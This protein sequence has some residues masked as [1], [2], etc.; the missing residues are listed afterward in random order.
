MPADPRAAQAFIRDPRFQS[1]T[2]PSAKMAMFRQYLA[3]E[4]AEGFGTLG[5]EEQTTV[6]SRLMTHFEP[7][8][9]TTAADVAEYV[10]V[11]GG[12]VRGA[13]EE[14]VRPLTGAL[15]GQP[16]STAGRVAAEVGRDVAELG[17]AVGV[18]KLAAPVIN[19][20]ARRFA[21]QGIEELVAGAFKTGGAAGVVDEALGA[22]SLETARRF[23]GEAARRAL[24]ERIARHGIEN[25]T[26]GALF[27]AT[28]ALEGEIANGELPPLSDILGS[29]FGAAALGMGFYGAGELLRKFRVRSLDDVV[30]ASQRFDPERFAKAQRDISE[31]AEAVTRASGGRLDRQGAVDL[32]MTALTEPIE[33]VGE[34][35]ALKDALRARPELL[36]SETGLHILRTQRKLSEPTVQL[37]DGPYLRVQYDDEAG[38]TV[39]EDLTDQAAQR[40]FARRLERGQVTVDTAVGDQ[41]SILRAGIR[42]G[43]PLET[44]VPAGGSRTFVAEGTPPARFEPLYGPANVPMVRPTEPTLADL[45]DIAAREVRTGQPVRPSPL[46]IVGARAARPEPAVRSPSDLAASPE[47]ISRLGRERAGGITYAARDVRGKGRERVL[48][49]TV[50]RIDTRPGPFEVIV[51]RGGTERDVIVEAG[52]KV[53]PAQLDRIRAEEVTRFR[54]EVAQRQTAATAGAPGL[55][56]PTDL[57]QGVL[58]PN[59]ARVYTAPVVAPPAGTVTKGTGGLDVTVVGEGD[60]LGRAP[61]R[62]P[63]GTVARLQWDPRLREFDVPETLLLLPGREGR[64]PSLTGEGR[65]LTPQFRAQVVPG[66]VITQTIQDVGKRDARPSI[67]VLAVDGD[68]V[69]LRSGETVLETDLATVARTVDSGAA[70]LAFDMTKLGEEMLDAMAAKF[71]VFTEPKPVPK[72]TPAELARDAQLAEELYAFNTQRAGQTAAPGTYGPDP[73]VGLAAKERAARRQPRT[74]GGNAFV[75]GCKPK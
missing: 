18:T 60:V 62:L 1:V 41:A 25:L 44:R 8:W 6:A 51:K 30:A 61:V 71:E 54:R 75:K 33:A 40:T 36:G 27:G 37:V 21:G 23:A 58:M 5:P 72:L 32:T 29:T 64:A 43:T 26:Q 42:A 53:K 16:E 48:P 68:K 7:T 52:A 73:N 69:L 45:A 55:P 70:R 65:A 12:A 22:A 19:S 56:A 2:D 57:Q 49:A 50:D 67:E 63:D 46:D 3:T 39:V 38:R 74:R 4:D 20:L 34:V 66:Q 9:A 31:I 14:T 10:P 47:A 17:A 59:G 35:Q 15:F 28:V 11:I 24:T 13:R